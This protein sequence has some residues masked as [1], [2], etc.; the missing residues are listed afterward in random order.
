MFQDTSVLKLATFF[1]GAISLAALI[2]GSALV[3]FERTMPD[4]LIALGSAAVGALS[5]LLSVGLTGGVKETVRQ[6]GETVA[7]A[8][9]LVAIAEPAAK[10]D[11]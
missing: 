6:A 10:A 11:Q 3:G 2:A 5:T 1:L 9:E 4:G 7:A 8:K